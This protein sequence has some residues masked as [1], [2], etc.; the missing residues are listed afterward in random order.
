MTWSE[1]I[2]HYHPKS[3][4]RNGVRSFL[5]LNG[6]FSLWSFAWLLYFWP[7]VSSVTKSWVPSFFLIGWLV[8][9]IMSFSSAYLGWDVLS[10]LT[11]VVSVGLYA[12]SLVSVFTDTRPFAGQYFLCGLICVMLI[13]F[14]TLAAQEL[15]NPEPLPPP[16]ADA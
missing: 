16:R 12:T 8:S 9:A 15:T 2:R 5:L 4:V 3:V 10:R 6:I 1:F 14:L 7:H 13:I 11:I